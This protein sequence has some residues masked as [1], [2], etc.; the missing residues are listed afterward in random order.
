[1][2]YSNNNGLADFYG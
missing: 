2:L 1:M